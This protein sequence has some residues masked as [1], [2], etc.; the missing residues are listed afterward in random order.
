ML[1]IG[2]YGTFGA[3]L[4]M[5]LAR[6]PAVELLVAGRDFSAARTFTERVAGTPIR[7][8]RRDARLKPVIG[9]LAPIS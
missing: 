5:A 4:S 8:D 9:E 3:R 6:L 1:V 7:L 2:G